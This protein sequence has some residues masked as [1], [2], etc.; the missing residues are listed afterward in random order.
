VITVEDV[1]FDTQRASL[2]DD[3]LPDLARL[4]D[5]LRAHPELKVQVQGHA[6]P[7]ELDEG[8]AGDLSQARAEAV[9]GY[10]VGQGIDSGRIETRAFGASA[11]VA[12]EDTAFGRGQNRRVQVLVYD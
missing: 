2:R 11:P 3:A 9:A 1:H 5:Y 10:L 4:A 6:D 8:A 7:T 12:P